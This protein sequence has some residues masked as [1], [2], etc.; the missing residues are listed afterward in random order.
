MAK[1][2]LHCVYVSLINFTFLRLHSTPLGGGRDTHSVAHLMSRVERGTVIVKCLLQEY[3][4]DHGQGSNPKS[5][6]S[7]T[8]FKSMCNNCHGAG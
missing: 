7:K 8:T 2:G 3:N 1:N 6:D 5:S 4:T